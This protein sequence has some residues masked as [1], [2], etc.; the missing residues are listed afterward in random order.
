MNQPSWYSIPRS[1][2]PA[3][4]IPKSTLSEPRQCGQNV[5]RAREVASTA[6]FNHHG[7]CFE[8][9][10]L[11]VDGFVAVLFDRRPALSTTR[12]AAFKAVFA[13][14][15]G[16]AFELHFR[17]QEVHNSGCQQLLLQTP[18]AL[19]EWQTFIRQITMQMV[20]A[21]GAQGES[22]FAGGMGRESACNV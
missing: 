6:V 22:A 3:M 4:Y 16:L 2:I 12:Y 10:N 1:H 15:I 18:S 20:G 21:N 11:S 5:V 7:P 13:A 19:E 17:R 8:D 14:V 9:E